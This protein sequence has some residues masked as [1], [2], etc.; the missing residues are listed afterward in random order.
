MPPPPLPYLLLLWTHGQAPSDQTRAALNSKQA[1]NSTRCG[2]WLGLVTAA[3]VQCVSGNNY[4]FSNYS[5][6]LKT[7]MGLTQLQL[8]DLS[9]A[10]DI[11]K[12]FGLLAGLASDHVPIWLLLAVGS[13]EGLLG[14][15]AQWMVVSGAVAPLPYWQTAS[16]SASA[17][18]APRG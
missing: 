18:T 6:A 1:S 15:S 12:A 9:V 17:G 2:W 14:Y 11:G 8:N 13:L 3:W 7:L 16:S 5:H 4:T 10:K